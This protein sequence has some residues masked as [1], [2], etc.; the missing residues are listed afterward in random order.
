MDGV[1]G[2]VCLRSP[3]PCTGTHGDRNGRGLEPSGWRLDLAWT[4]GGRRLSLSQVGHLAAVAIKET[5]ARF[6]IW[7]ILEIACSGL[8]R[9]RTSL[10][11]SSATST[12]RIGTRV[13]HLTHGESTDWDLLPSCSSAGEQTNVV[14]LF[15]QL[16][17]GFF[18]STAS[19]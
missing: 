10:I 16:L 6:E 3:A 9:E 15:S 7:K 19:A 4:V 5:L 18:F 8:K 17:F 2:W 12:D 13:G 14:N 1:D 11:R